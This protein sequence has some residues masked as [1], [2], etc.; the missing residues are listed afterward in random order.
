MLILLRGMS[1][2]YYNYNDHIVSLDILKQWSYNQ[3]SHIMV[4]FFFA[5]WQYTMVQEL[6]GLRQ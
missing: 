5:E 3:N 1:E 2:T 6:I 4:P